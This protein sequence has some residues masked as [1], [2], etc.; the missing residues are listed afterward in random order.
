MKNLTQKRNAKK[1]SFAQLQKVSIQ[2]NQLNSIK[3]G[4][5]GV[6][7]EEHIGD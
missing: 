5:D 2:K 7:I 4:S 3:G 6:I 1:Q